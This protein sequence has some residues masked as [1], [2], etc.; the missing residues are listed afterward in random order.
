MSYNLPNRYMQISG[1]DV[2]KV[3]TTFGF[4][5]KVEKKLEL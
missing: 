3:G 2:R 5:K 1:Q 4:W